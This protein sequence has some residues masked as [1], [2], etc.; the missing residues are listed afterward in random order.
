MIEII[1]II[2]FKFIKIFHMYLLTIQRF[3]YKVMQIKCRI[4]KQSKMMKEK[5]TTKE[6]SN[7]QIYKQESRDRKLN[8][9]D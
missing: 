1:K 3:I 7:V 6:Y 4:N 5:K 8:K 2:E 9:I